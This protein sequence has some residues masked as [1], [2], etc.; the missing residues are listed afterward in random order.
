VGRT[1][2]RTA[3]FTAAFTT[4]RT[5]GFTFA[6]SVGVA[7]MAFFTAVRRLIRDFFWTDI[8]SS[9]SFGLCRLDRP[10]PDAFVC[11]MIHAKAGNRDGINNGLVVF[12]GLRTGFV[13]AGP[14]F[15]TRS[16]EHAL[17]FNLRWIKF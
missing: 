6:T 1:A 17:I 12:N 15:H 4:G 3:A 2:A 11:S 9:P 16:M 14:L 13:R 7:S 5:A 8:G 10:S